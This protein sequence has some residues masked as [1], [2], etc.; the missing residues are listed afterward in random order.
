MPQPP[1][2]ATAAGLFLAL[3]CGAAAVV[4]VYRF[5]SAR[6]AAARPMQAVAAGGLA[7]QVA[8]VLEHGLQLGFWFT[9]PEGTPWL[10]SWASGTADGLQY[11][12][13]L[14]P[15]AGRPTSLGVEMLHLTGNVIFLGALTAWQVAM[16]ADNRHIASLNRAEKVQ[17]FHVAEHVLL[18]ITLLLFGEASG[19]STLFGFI[20]GSALV[21]LRVWFHFGI[22]AIATGFALR[23]A[24]E[25]WGLGRPQA[26]SPHEVDQRHRGAVRR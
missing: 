14:V 18:V 12:C 22:N 19:I 9:T 26:G 16:R 11:F 25:T 21:A 13:S 7:F 15:S 20:E 4:T 6:C 3:G 10:S 5:S 8:H 24:Q 17:M 2:L 23:A 1:L